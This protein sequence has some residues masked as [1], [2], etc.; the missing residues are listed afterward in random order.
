MVYH[1][2]LFD[3][4][5]STMLH[6]DLPV[7]LRDFVYASD[8]AAKPP[9]PSVFASLSMTIF[10]MLLQQTVYIVA[11]LGQSGVPA[12]RSPVLGFIPAM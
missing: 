11:F 8:P 5:I 7:S 10:H 12:G 2:L 3:L 1:S 9:S 6:C 4:N